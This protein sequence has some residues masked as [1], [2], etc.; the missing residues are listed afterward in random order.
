[1]LRALLLLLHYTWLAIALTTNVS[2]ACSSRLLFAVDRR[3]G[4]FT[5][6]SRLLLVELLPN[7]DSVLFFLFLFYFISFLRFLFFFRI[8]LLCV[9]IRKTNARFWVSSCSRSLVQRRPQNAHAML[10]WAQLSRCCYCMMM[11]VWDSLIS[12]I[13]TVFVSEFQLLFFFFGSKYSVFWFSLVVHTIYIIRFSSVTFWQLCTHVCMV[14][15][16]SLD[17]RDSFSVSRMTLRCPYSQN[18]RSSTM[19]WW[20]ITFNAFTS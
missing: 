16:S 10:C 1:M 14:P 4:R 9:N 19:E 13:L 6:T 18:F 12:L 17:V 2:V 5:L 15:L 11:F 3:R 7:N 8:R 20:Q